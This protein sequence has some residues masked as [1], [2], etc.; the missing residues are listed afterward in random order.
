MK[1]Y[2]ANTERN[3]M[4]IE[5]RVLDYSKEFA[6]QRIY[7]ISGEHLSVREAK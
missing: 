1:T 2:I 6:E 3:G 7:E 5:Y 4:L